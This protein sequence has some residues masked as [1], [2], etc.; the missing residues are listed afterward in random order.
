MPH[1]V[2]VPGQNRKCS[3]QGFSFQHPVNPVGVMQVDAAP[4]RFCRSGCTQPLGSEL[5]PLFAQT[6]RAQD[7]VF[8]ELVPVGPLEQV[9][10][11]VVRALVLD[12]H[13]PDGICPFSPVGFGK[14]CVD[15]E[16]PVV[17]PASGLAVISG[18]P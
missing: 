9:T 14:R 10:N 3:R 11:F 15:G 8:P 16:K 18:S 2:P 1:G 6:R 4:G 13:Q 7:G 5:I 17:N 12:T